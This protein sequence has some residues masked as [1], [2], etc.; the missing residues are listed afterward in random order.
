MGLF[1]QSFTVMIVEDSVPQLKLIDKVLTKIEG[2]K[3][4]LC[5]DVFE[6][7][8]VL[9]AVGKVDMLVLDVNLPFA[10]GLS[11]LAK[12]RSMDRF[13]ELPIL[14]STAEQDMA[15]L[16]GKGSSGVLVKPYDIGQLKTFVEAFRQP[17]S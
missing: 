1:Q 3:S 8:A 6:A 17:T 15:K 2:V 12:L 9:Q 11:L 13:A 10:G 7:Y 16:Q 4:L 14:I 5:G